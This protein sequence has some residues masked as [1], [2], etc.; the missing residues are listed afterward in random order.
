MVVRSFAFVLS[1]VL[2]TAAIGCSAASDGE[3]S[4]ASANLDQ[5]GASWCPTAETL[6]LQQSPSDY[7]RP[8]E[9]KLD[10]ALDG[11]TAYFRLTSGTV[12]RVRFMHINAEEVT[13]SV[14]SQHSNAKATPFGQYTKTYVRNLLQNAKTIHIA[15]HRSPTSWYSPEADVFGRWLAL[16]WVDGELLQRRLVGEGFS[17]YYTKYGC[18][19]GKLHDLLLRS[20]AEANQQNK[21]VWSSDH[22]DEHR[23]ILEE[24]IKTN[25]CR[26]NPFEG[27]FYC[28][29]D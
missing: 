19:K 3:T 24:W 10:S 11:D 15:S 4:E 20:E 9:V 13:H 18:A 27:D 17:A 26:P 16:V 28:P 5:Q 23:A 14:G 7:L 29:A 6:S 2:A 1:A 21:G 8:I 22:R 12:Q 25:S